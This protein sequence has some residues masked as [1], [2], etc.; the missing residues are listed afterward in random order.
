M[1]LLGAVCARAPAQ[2]LP[3]TLIDYSIDVSLDPVSRVLDGSETIRWT[4]PSST[5][6]V[7]RVP[8]HLYLNAFA[9]EDTSWTRSASLIGRF[10]ADA[11][12]DLHGDPWGWS[13]LRAVRQAGVA[14]EWRPIAPD[15]GNPLDRTLIEVEL[16]T[17]IAPGE[18][19]ELEVEWDAKLPVAIAR[20]GGYDDYFMVAQWFPKVAVFETAGVRGAAADGWKAHQFHGATEFYADY[21]DFDV[22]IGLPSE[23]EVAATGLK[24]GATER[25]GLTWHEYEQRAVHDFAFAAGRN[26]VELVSSHDP[27]GPGDAVELHLFVPA[28]REEAAARWRTALE[29]SLDVLSSRVGPYP[30]ATIT[31]VQPPYR[32]VATGGMEYPTLFL[33]LFDDEVLDHPLLASVRL[34]E[35]VIAHEFTHQYFYGLIGSNE[36]EEAFLDE[37]FTEYWGTEALTGTYSDGF[38]SLVG[39]RIAAWDFERVLAAGTGRSAPLLARPSYALRDF[40]LTAQFYSRPALTLKT[41]ENRFGRPVL[42]RIFAAYYARWRFRHPRFED[43]V[44]VARDV[45]G[46]DVAEFVLDAFTQAD[47][48]DYRIVSLD[49][50]EWEPPRGRLVTGGETIEPEVPRDDLDRVGK[51]LAG[52]GGTI[53]MERAD[54]GNVAND[55]WAEMERIA[56][57]SEIGV[58]DPDWK[59]EEMPSYYE[60]NVAVEG[61]AW[62]HLPVDVEFRFADGATVRDRWDGRTDARHYRFVH[63]VPLAE[64]TIDRH[65]SIALDPDRANNARRRDG[66]GALARDWAF[67][68]GAFVQLISEALT[69]WL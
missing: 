29:G 18:T 24:A 41:L 7:E 53:V 69:Q 38:G 43:F 34:P 10:D 30:Y 21:A 5:A 44:D 40:N 9:H 31:L 42:D 54:S 25:D 27:T 11:V 3:D 14:L 12:V 6:S 66:D 61:P 33:G 45:G 36:F 47:A 50:E 48:P 19:L 60:S 39:R 35:Y 65:A 63:S 28:S 8:M 22:R 67:W 32:H 13:E 4:N 46:D 1:C 55:A 58:A 51:L 16:A 2:E 49:V 17:P 37:G 68:A 56:M 20:T 57:R 26:Y 15:D 52:S 62:R 59:P 64:V 23:W